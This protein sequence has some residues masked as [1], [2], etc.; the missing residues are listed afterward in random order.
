MKKRLELK[1]GGERKIVGE[2]EVFVFVSV[3]QNLYNFCKTVNSIQNESLEGLGENA[4]VMAC[5]LIK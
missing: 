2:V 1:K 4:L 5:K 3:C